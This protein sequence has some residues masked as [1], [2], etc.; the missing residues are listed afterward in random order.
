VLVEVVDGEVAELGGVDVG[1]EIESVGEIEGEK[2]SFGD[3]EIGDEMAD[4]GEVD[5]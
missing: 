5:D 4:V 3:V 1:V 2:T